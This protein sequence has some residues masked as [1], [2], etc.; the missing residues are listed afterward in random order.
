MSAA[1]NAGATAARLSFGQKLM[2]GELLLLTPRE[3]VRLVLFV[4]AVLAVALWLLLG[5]IEPPPP[6]H[7]RIST[8]SPTGAYT[9]YAKLYAAEFKKHG[10]ELEVLTSAGSVDNLKRLDDA[11]QK[12]DL[13]F[14]Q[15]GVGAAS[16][17]PRIESLASVAYEPIW[18]FFDKKRFAQ[19]P[20]SVRELMGHPLAID[21]PGSGVRAAALRLLEVSGVQPREDLLLPL[22]GMAAVEALLAGTLHAAVLVAAVDSP[23]VQKALSQD[24]GLVN[25]DAADAYVRL[26]P[27]LAKVSLPR[28]V[29]NIAADLPR[30]DVTLIAATAN[31]VARSDLH[32]A[33]MF[34][35]LD[36]A[37][38]IH[39][40]PAAV[41]A[42][43]E[44]PSERNLDYTQSEESKRYF[45]SG[46]PF[47]QQYLPF[48]LAN[49]VG[50]LIATLV[51][52][53]AIGLPLMRLFPAFL[54]WQERAK[55]AQLYE[56]VLSIEHQPPA[57]ADQR[58]ASL[59]RLSDIDQHLPSLKLGA[60]H[61]VDLY[62]LKAHIDMVKA[63]LVAA[64]G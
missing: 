39:K 43:T 41:N 44:F 64:P 18:F 46:R 49:L 62:N 10:I 21:A 56:E 17:H 51:P 9:R 37:S 61:H 52:V 36:I 35:M 8:G 19:A 2:Q 45:K 58:A 30:E 1:A 20:A 5:V 22:G 31:L 57:G 11:A 38:G 55:L 7:I 42:P 13:A 59:A 4:L 53:L 32:P 63:R 60:D 3:Q 48:W 14:V 25:L 40:R 6:K 12:I 29:V 24:L 34:L 50:R 54:G 28:G 15:G 16:E 23:A 33:V 26:L 47:L 27:W